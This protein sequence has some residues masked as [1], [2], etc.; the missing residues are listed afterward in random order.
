MD[1]GKID[2]RMISLNY[3][4]VDDD[5]FSRNLLRTSL[6]QYGI[7]NIYD[8][9]NAIQATE[10]IKKHH[11]DVLLLDH[12]MPGLTGLE[13][14]RV[15]REGKDG[16]TNTNVKIVMVTN[17]ADKDT[18]IEAKKLGIQDFLVKPISPEKLVMRLKH[19]LIGD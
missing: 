17:F 9:T 2:P 10:M 8:A 3:M 14:A 11:I 15:I 19:T 7:N 5:A 12:E 4:I 1:S 6:K 18:V 13:F 16:I